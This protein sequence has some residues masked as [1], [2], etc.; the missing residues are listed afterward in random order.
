MMTARQGLSLVRALHTGIYLMM[1]SASFVV[2]FGALMGRYG[3]WLWVALVL[4]GVETAVFLG[5]GLKCPL[6]ALAVKYGASSLRPADTFL[7]ERMTR[8]TLQVFGPL[9]GVSVILLAARWL[10]R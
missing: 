10:L 2:L 3:L 1:A 9:I 7:P 4:V 5:F 8:H 6:T